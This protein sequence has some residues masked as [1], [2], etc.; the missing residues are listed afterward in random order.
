MHEND[1]LSNQV[2]TLLKD[3]YA[4]FKFDIVGFATS[5]GKVLPLNLEPGTLGNVIE[6]VLI[7]HLN[8]SVEGRKDIKVSEGGFRHYPDVELTGNLF[9]DQ[10][11]AL[12][13]KAARRSK[14]N[15]NRTQSRVT[16]YSFGT[17]LKDHTRKFPQTLRPFGDYALH[18]D[19][20][21]FFDVDSDEGKVSNFDIVIAEPWKIATKTRSSATR[22]YV[23][24][25][26]EISKMKSETGGDFTTPQEFYDYWAH[27]PRRGQVLEQVD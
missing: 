18:I 25:V 23:G 24:A 7:A 19:L 11:I 27:I 10:I 17:Y 14:V 6:G 26:M 8:Q 4:S 22:D 2:R 12:D 1:Q 16:L 15:P 13:I 3:I 5:T 9:N 20:V 21:I